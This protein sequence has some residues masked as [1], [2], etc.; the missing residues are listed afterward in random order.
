MVLQPMTDLGILL[1]M[2]RMFLK[3]FNKGNRVLEGTKH[4][5][6][7]T[8]EFDGLMRKVHSAAKLSIGRSRVENCALAKCAVLYG[9]RR[10][11]L[12]FLGTIK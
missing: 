2:P 6:Q 9:K 4:A 7:K 10:S 11:K 8:G 3:G 1:Q 5:H 12:G